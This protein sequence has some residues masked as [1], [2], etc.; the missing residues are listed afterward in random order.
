VTVSRC[1]PNE[2]FQYLVHFVT[3]VPPAEESSLRSRGGARHRSQARTSA[4][5]PWPP[6]PSST[7]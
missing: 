2:F 1:H 4:F 5:E 7:A 3:G 6:R